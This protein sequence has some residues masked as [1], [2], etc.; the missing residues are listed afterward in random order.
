M[1]ELIDRAREYL[2]DRVLDLADVQLFIE[3]YVRLFDEN[4]LLREKVSMLQFPQ[5]PWEYL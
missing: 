3:E 4:K 5:T 2:K 1:S